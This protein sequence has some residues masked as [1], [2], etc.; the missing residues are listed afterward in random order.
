MLLVCAK[1]RQKFHICDEIAVALAVDERVATAT[2][3]M[4]CCVESTGALTRGQMVIERQLLTTS[5]PTTVRVV[6]A[7]NLER[8]IQL[9]TAA[10]AD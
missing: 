3:E 1:D 9:L 6:T 7:V 2:V 10:L 8:C 5:Y 4:P